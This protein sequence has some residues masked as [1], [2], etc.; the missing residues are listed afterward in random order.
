VSPTERD[1]LTIAYGNVVL[2]PEV[3]ADCEAS[4][5]VTKT[6][7]ARDTLGRIDTEATIRNEGARMCWIVFRDRVA[8]AKRPRAETTPTHAVSS[9]ARPKP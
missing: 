7:V 3:M 8:E 5:F 4:Y 6:T 2:P 9:T 1:P